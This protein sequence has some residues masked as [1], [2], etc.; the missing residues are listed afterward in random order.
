[1]LVIKLAELAYFGQLPE[2]VLMSVVGQLLRQRVVIGVS[3]GLDAPL[4]PASSP[5]KCAVVHLDWCNVPSW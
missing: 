4:R 2:T 1:M 3:S 5:D